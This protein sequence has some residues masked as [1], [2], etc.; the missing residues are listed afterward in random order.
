MSRLIASRKRL[1]RV[2][3]AQH[4]QAVA[5]V[6][7]ARDEASQITENARRIALV[8]DELIGNEGATTGALLASKRELATRL[9]RAGRQLDGALYDANRRIDQR[10]AERVVAGRD[11]EIA[12][13]LKDKA[14]AAREARR[15]ARLAALPSYRRMQD[16]GTE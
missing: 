10:D 15:E 1:L 9:E 2:R 11:R 6:M 4:S 13:R 5:A 3:H 7:S 16:R 14:H 12:E 8:R